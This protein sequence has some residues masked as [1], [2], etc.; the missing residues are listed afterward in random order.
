M[1][2]FIARINIIIEAASSDAAQ[3]IFRNCI[4]SQPDVDAWDFTAVDGPTQFFMIPEPP[5]NLDDIFEQA[6]NSDE[7]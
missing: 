7:A 6:V 3:Q 2:R 5:V 1:S 4:E